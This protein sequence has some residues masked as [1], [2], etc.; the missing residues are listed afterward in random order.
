VLESTTYPGRPRT[1]SSRSGAVRVA[2]GSDFFLAFSPE[3]EDPGNPNFSCRT[4]PK[5]S[6]ASR[7]RAENIAAQF[8]RRVKDVVPSRGTRVAESGAKFWKT[9]PRGDIALVND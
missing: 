4:I 5:L 3:R 9:L 1:C 8:T 6:A 2:G 7:R